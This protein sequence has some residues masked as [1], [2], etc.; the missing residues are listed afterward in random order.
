MTYKKHIED[1]KTIKLN[2]GH[3][4]IGN[5]NL[6]ISIR[7]VSLF[8]KGMKPHRNWRLKHVKDYFEVKG[9]APNVLKQ[10]KELREW[11]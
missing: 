5:Y 6:A 2:D 1:G 3:I 8:C 11:K 4:N 7:D 9:N 10:L